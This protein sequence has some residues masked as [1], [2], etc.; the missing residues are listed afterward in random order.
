M[1]Q[2][3]P[4]YGAHETEILLVDDVMENCS[5]YCKTGSCEAIA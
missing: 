1:F 5:R 4:I 3:I 2:N